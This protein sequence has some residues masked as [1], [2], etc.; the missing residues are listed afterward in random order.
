[1]GDSYFLMELESSPVEIMPVALGEPPG[2]LARIGLIGLSSGMTCE[3]EMHTMLPP[4]TQVLTSRV[5]NQNHV[6]LATLADMEGDLVRAVSTLLPEGHLD[7]LVYSCTSGTIAMGEDTVFE[8]LR[9]VRPGVAVTTPF[10]G[11][12]TALN[13]LGCERITMLTPYSEEVTVA[14]RDELVRR[15]MTIVRTV[16]FGLTADSEMSRVEPR[17]VRDMVIKTDHPDAEAVF[18]SCTALRTSAILDELEQTLG[19]PVVTSNQ[20]LVWHSLTLAGY[21]SPV[22]GY[23][24]L[25]RTAL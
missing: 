20:A 16:A 21:Q 18:V 8:R 14:M 4:G 3:E 19:K 25:L 9:S 2:H 1:M 22:E 11:A 10:T 7:A 12:V 15:G 24:Q 6:N 13:R 5:A 23:G 17:T